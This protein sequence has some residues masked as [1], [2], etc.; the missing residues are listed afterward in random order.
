M[1]PALLTVQDIKS[2]I[3]KVAQPDE[4]LTQSQVLSKFHLGLPTLKTYISM[5][6]LWHISSIFSTHH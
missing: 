5:A 4:R 3:F 1:K 2:F 6:L